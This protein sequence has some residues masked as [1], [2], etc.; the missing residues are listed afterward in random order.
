MKA[1]DWVTLEYGNQRVEAEILLISE[2]QR[3][4]MLQ[5]EAILGGYVG[6]MPILQDEDGVYRDLF[7]NEEVRIKRVSHTR[8]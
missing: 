3:S 2:N 7:K 8:P 4:M 6:A 5:F 1:G